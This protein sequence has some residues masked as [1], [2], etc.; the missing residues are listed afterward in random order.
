M[1]SYPGWEVILSVLVE[2]EDLVRSGW[3]W[4]LPGT[5]DHESEEEPLS[6]GLCSLP[7]APRPLTDMSV[8]LT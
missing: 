5:L 3:V 2:A 8:R 4:S 6:S 7:S 1:P